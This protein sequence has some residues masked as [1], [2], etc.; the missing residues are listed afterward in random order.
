MTWEC[1]YE[2]QCCLFVYVVYR[3]HCLLSFSTLMKLMVGLGVCSGR[4]HSSAPLMARYIQTRLWL[5]A[6][7]GKLSPP[8]FVMWE[9]Y[10][11]KAG[12]FVCLY[13]LLG[14][15]TTVIFCPHGKLS[16]PVFVIGKHLS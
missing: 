13:G 16:P 8:V 1:S 9:A 7:H 10:L 5:A 4:F 14:T 2:R 15:V 12:A 11:L 3:A 6:T